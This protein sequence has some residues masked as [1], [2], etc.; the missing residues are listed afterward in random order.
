MGTRRRRLGR[1]APASRDHQKSRGRPRRSR[2]PELPPRL[3][4]V[5][6]GQRADP[7]ILRCHLL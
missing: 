2:R 3:T 5:F 4:T 6:Q 1:R 7:E